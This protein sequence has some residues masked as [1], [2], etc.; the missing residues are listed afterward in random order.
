MAKKPT[1]RPTSPD[2][3]V[4]RHVVLAG[5]V[6]GLLLIFLGV[7]FLCFGRS[8]LLSSL[9]TCVGFGLVLASFE[10][11][12]SGSWAGWTAT[13]SGALAIVLLH[14]LDDQPM[15]GWKSISCATFPAITPA[16]ARSSIIEVH[17]GRFP[18]GVAFQLAFLIAVPALRNE[19]VDSLRSLS[20]ACYQKLIMSPC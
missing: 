14:G 2:P 5:I 12:A 9:M 13:G 4:P 11:K 18:R 1:K 17:A 10:S 3:G 19:L 8:S 7:G 16:A 6:V 15:L 20:K